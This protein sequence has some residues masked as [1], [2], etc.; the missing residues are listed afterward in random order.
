MAVPIF[1]ATNCLKLI[2]NPDGHADLV[3][4]D[5][6]GLQQGGVALSFRENDGKFYAVHAN[7]PGPAFMPDANGK[8][9]IAEP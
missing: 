8:L 1:T 3:Y 7:S 5:E 6:N 2:P 4:I 9:Y